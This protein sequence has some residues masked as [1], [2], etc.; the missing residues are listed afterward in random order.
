M[1]E[2]LSNIKKFL[3][4]I[5]YTKG[6]WRGFLTAEMYDAFQSVFTVQVGVFIIA[7]IE[8]KNIENIKFWAIILVV[9]NIFSYFF[10]WVAEMCRESANG[11]VDMG[12]RRK[13][14]EK[15]IHLDNTKVETI[16]TG[17]MQ[18][19]IFDGISNRVGLV[20]DLFVAIL[21]E[22]LAIIYAFTLIATKSPNRTYFLGFT[23]L[24]I[25]AT[26]LIRVGLGILQKTRKQAKEINMDLARRDI[27][28][29]MS[30]FEILQNNKLSIEMDK[31]EDLINKKV[32]LRQRGN[33]KK[34]FW[35]TPA[36]GIMDAMKIG[37]YVFVGIGIVTGNYT[38]AYIMLLL[39]LLNIVSR[40][41]WNIRKYLKEWY[42]SIVHIDKLWETFDSISSMKNT[43]DIKKFSPKHGDI[44]LKNISFSYEKNKV[45]ENFNL[46]IQGG[47]KTAFVGESGGG[48][49]TLIKLLAGYIRPD[50][51]E[52]IVDGQKLSKIKLTDYYR[53][54]GYLTQ[55]PSVFDGTIHENLIYALD[56]EP[57][58]K[59]LEKTIKDAKCEFIREFDNGL[60]TEIGERGVRLSGGQKQRLAIAKIM[61]KNPNIILLDEPTS[62]LDSFNEEQINIAL[63][64]LF[65]GKTVVVVAHR[66]Q[67]VK[68][69]DRII[70]LEQGKIIEEGTHN[71][72]VKLGG[73]YK[74]MLDLQSG[75]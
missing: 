41:V 12:L 49:T 8:T 29:L 16:G 65:K 2:A 43:K 1:K 47:T 24:F 63:H 4:P 54:I 34:I 36:S 62:A 71:E 33:T 15:Y 66:L 27:K 72:L 9:V 42:K 48:K 69:A 45:F 55:D 37:I 50:K 46:E 11:K 22:I 67:T 38:F 30:K 61:L 53:H 51:G 75:F 19:I 17:K 14:F 52:V 57:D 60:E 10:G 5:G 7:A 21:V 25:V 73:K 35:Q 64:N 28:I 13:Y 68:Q 23:L 58:T 70:F 32:K 26:F 59:H 3:S 20:N 6:R 44:F 56:K 74:R 39:Q 31:Q 18:N 40:Y